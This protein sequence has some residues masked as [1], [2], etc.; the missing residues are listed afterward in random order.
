MGALGD[1]FDE[2]CSAVTDRCQVSAHSWR[3][4]VKQAAPFRVSHRGRRTDRLVVVE[5]TGQRRRQ[6]GRRFLFPE[7]SCQRARPRTARERPVA[8][9]SCCSPIG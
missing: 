7:R 1:R 5:M 3:I 2:D 9:R 4:L 8:T 6:L